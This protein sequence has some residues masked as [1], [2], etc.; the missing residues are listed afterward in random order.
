MP[1]PQKEGTF[2]QGRISLFQNG[3]KPQIELTP[4]KADNPLFQNNLSPIS[5]VADMKRR[6][7]T[8]FAAMND[9]PTPSNRKIELDKGKKY[10]A[11]KEDSESNIKSPNQNISSTR[12][13]SN[14]YNFSPSNRRK[15]N[16]S[17]SPQLKN[18]NQDGGFNTSLVNN[19]NTI[20]MKKSLSTN[21]K[22]NMAMIDTSASLRRVRSAG[23]EGLIPDHSK[24]N[25]S[26][27]ATK[28]PIEERKAPRHFFPEEEVPSSNHTILS[29]DALKRNDEMMQGWYG[30]KVNGANAKG[31]RGFLDKTRDVPN[32]IDDDTESESTRQNVQ[33][34][35]LVMDDESD[36]FDGLSTVVDNNDTNRAKQAFTPMKASSPPSSIPFT[37][38]KRKV[39][40]EP[41]T[42]KS[43]RHTPSVSPSP[44]PIP[45]R[46]SDSRSH[47]S[48]D[49]HSI[50]NEHHDHDARY[51]SLE[52]HKSCDSSEHNSS[53]SSRL[54]LSMYAV[55]PIQVKRLV[56]R[57]R[58][59]GKR[60]IQKGCDPSVIE[61]ANKA[62][63][64]FEMRSRIMETDIER[65][66]DRNGGTKV[67]DDI[68]T[69]K[70]YQ[71][72]NR[73]RDAVIVSKAWRDGASPKDAFTANWL[74]RAS[75]VYHIQRPPKNIQ[76]SRLYSTSMWNI[77]SNYTLEKVSWVDDTEFSLLRCPSLGDRSMRGFEIF[78]VGDCQSLLLKLTNERCVQ[79]RKALNDAT[80]RQYMAEQLMREESELDDF[81]M[82]T[83]A[84]MTYLQ[85]MEEV[86]TI[87]K[88]LVLAENAFE[89]V[90]DRIERLIRKYETLLERMDNDDDS[91]TSFEISLSK[92]E[93]ALSS[94]DESLDNED[95]S[96]CKERLARKSQ[97]AELK[98]KIAY[99]EALM[100]RVEAEKSKKEALKLMAEKQKELNDMQKKLDDLE[101][102]SAMIANEYEMKLQSQKLLNLH[103]DAR[104][105]ISSFQSIT[106]QKSIPYNGSNAN[107]ERQGEL[108]D[109][110][111]AKFR[112]RK[113]ASDNA[114]GKVHQR[115]QFY[116]RSL[117][118]VQKYAG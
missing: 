104:S 12:R 86:K 52:D 110:I 89:L 73:V 37:K 115:L 97:R 84:E 25:S 21:F 62:F 22:P 41:K 105:Q 113:Q 117:Q 35:S 38:I 67:V 18:I 96:V 77:G 68:V 61:D 72:S 43:H 7:D 11:T 2:E 59:L 39:V 28:S 36:V 20:P 94:E 100:A 93:H 111:K 76:N 3:G 80:S 116:E 65:G 31:Y 101:T 109:R 53:T 15:G 82:M 13:M 24:P 106:D 30:A 51:T 118:A 74:T 99:Q 63:A 75:E 57:F 91:V 8:Q 1:K 107:S 85:C 64:L 23:R 114:A 55:S 79:L 48:V 92:D 29:E 5:H 10:T 26:L 44:S 6:F 54:D 16:A 40:D 70:Y 4:E 71:T 56:K 90:K 81:S 78:T 69:T 60:S 58:S 50:R 66:I 14:E 83:N 47:L 102:K 49:T 98:A 95:S 32:L 103:S 17:E 33:K 88:T 34:S 9:V 19:Y 27:L 108:R 87:S 42:N 45:F 46:R 112:E